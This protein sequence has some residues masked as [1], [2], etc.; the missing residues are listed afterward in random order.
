M[1]N[2]LFVVIVLVC[3]VFGWIFLNHGFDSGWVYLLSILAT[4]SLSYLVCDLFF[5]DEKKFIADQLDQNNKELQAHKNELDI[6]KT[7]SAISIP[8]SEVADLQKRFDTSEIDRNDLKGTLESQAITISTLNKKIEAHKETIATPTPP[9]TETVSQKV[10]EHSHIANDTAVAA[11]TVFGISELVH[12]E[13]DSTPNIETHHEVITTSP[14]LELPTL[15]ENITAPTFGEHNEISISTSQLE[16]PKLHENITSPT[17]E[18]HREVIT[19]S[20]E[21]E[22]PKLHE[23]ITSP[24]IEEHREVITPSPELELSTLHEIVKPKDIEAHHGVVDNTLTLDPTNHIHTEKPHDVIEPTTFLSES[25]P[26]I[27]AEFVRTHLKSEDDDIKTEH[28][29]ANVVDLDVAHK[30]EV[31]PIFTSLNGIKHSEHMP[32]THIAQTPP[33]D[34]DA[35]Q[36]SELPPMD[37]LKIVEGI[38]PRLELILYNGGIRTFKELAETRVDRLKE[39]MIA[40]GKNPNF[41]D[42]S[43]WPE[44][45]RLLANGEMEKFKAYIKWLDGGKISGVD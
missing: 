6:L 7:Q 10:Q 40:A 13:V 18:E 31:V 29:P 8:Q 16:L 32:E 15:H 20:P 11:V 43:T 30:T 14:E 1:R 22:L 45:A 23:N 25:V 38:G 33:V 37:D 27:G 9:T 19:P 28:T 4:G 42:P 21:L 41:N 2:V 12:H 3:L 17:I 26:P 36:S 39:I 34:R 35:P 24:T 44:Q 5:Q